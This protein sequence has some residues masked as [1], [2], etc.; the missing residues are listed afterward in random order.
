[1]NVLL[2]SPDHDLFGDEPVYWDGKPVGHVR[3]G[4]FGHSLGAACGIAHIRGDE[5]LT[6]GRL[7][8]GTFEVDIAGVRVPAQVSL[9]PFFDPE[10]SRILC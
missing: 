8:A 4:G 3:S 10:R 6:G 1:V 5:P 9:K 7:A 2:S